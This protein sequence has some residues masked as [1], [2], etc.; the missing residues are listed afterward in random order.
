ME[1]DRMDECSSCGPISTSSIEKVVKKAYNDFWARQKG[2]NTC[3]SDSNVHSTLLKKLSLRKGMKVL[4][5]GSG[6]GETV[7]TIAEKV[8]PNGK[9]VGVDFSS[10]GIALAQEKARRRNLDGVAEF[11]LANAVKLPFSDNYFDAVISECVV[12]LISDKQQA[13]NEKVRVLKPG[14]KVVMHDVISLVSMP[15]IMTENAQLYCGCVGGAV[16]KD[17]YIRMMEKAGLTNIE[18]IDFT[19]EN[20]KMLNRIIIEAALD[21][22]DEQEFQEVIS[23]VRKGGIGYALFLGTKG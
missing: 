17:E 15:K 22:E 8:K 18:T 14:G 3:C 23:F 11:H 21:I 1:D 12:C 19:E 6:S 4:D 9:A 20:R 7:L 10:D 16:S 13:L 2:S 5:I